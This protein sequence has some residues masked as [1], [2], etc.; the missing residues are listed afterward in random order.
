MDSS[1]RTDDIEFGVVGVDKYYDYVLL[2]CLN[3]IWR[4]QKQNRVKRT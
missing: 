2:V 4:T 1:Q 3:W